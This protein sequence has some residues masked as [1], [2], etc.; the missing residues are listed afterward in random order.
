MITINILNDNRP[1]GNLGSE[2]GLS[3][4]IEKDGERILFDT[5]PSDIILRNARKMNIDLE[6]VNTI[7]L[8]HGH[9]DHGNGLI[10]LGREGGKKR[11]LICHPEVFTGKYH[12]GNHVYIGL[13][14][15]RGE[16][17]SRFELLET[18]EPLQVMEDI[19][20]L[21]EIPRLND[22]ESKK[23]SF[24]KKD[25]ADDFM[26]DDSGIAIRTLKGLI[27]ITGCG[28]AGICN[29]I[30]HAVK[31][32]G[33]N[34]IVAAMGG[35]HLKED[36]RQTKGVVDCFIRMGVENAFPSHC[37]ELPALARF[38]AYYKNNFVRSG[39]VYRFED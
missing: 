6:D 26:P 14:L 27:I 9:Y 4:L 18:R 7:V 13:P 29:T 15:S 10:H 39:D 36:D 32:T 28:H 22:F 31:I 38:Y 8:S 24:E 34:R 33:E 35:F 5:G 20:F 30:A 23:T 25:G 3:W 17:V 37:T 12:K 19:F 16:V 11:K 21:G 1:S 2:H